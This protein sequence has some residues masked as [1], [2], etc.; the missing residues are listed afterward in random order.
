MISVNNKIMRLLS[1][2][3][4]VGLL[5]GFGCS[6]PSGGDDDGGGNDGGGDNGGGN[7]TV[8][9]SLTANASPS[10]GGSVDPSSGTFDEGEQVEV[11][12]TA[13][14]GWEFTGWS[15]DISSSENPLT[16]TINEDTDLTAEFS[17]VTNTYDLSVS[18]T[19]SEGGSVSPESGTYEEGEQVQV[20]AT[21]ASGWSFAGWSGDV[22]SSDNPLTVTMNSDTDLTASFEE[23]AKAYSNELMV[24]DGTYSETVTFGMNSN[25]TSGYDSGLDDEAPP[26]PPEGSFHANF[27]ISGYNLYD[28]YRP[29]QKQQT[30]WDL[31]FS[32]SSSNSISISWDFSSSNHHGSLTLVD[33]VN[34]PSVEI[35]MSSQSSYNV[36]DSVNELHIIQE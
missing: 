32:P 19:P 17:E 30:V 27:V 20:T 35:D 18:A 31:N 29:V 28:D 34:N 33:D 24:T 5:A 9:Y 11:A 36:S 10:Q 1:V 25:A 21:A 26:T 6:S 7:E 12:A 22:T 3:V 15:G 8:T 2:L 16:F 23:N 4:V 13:A 14:D